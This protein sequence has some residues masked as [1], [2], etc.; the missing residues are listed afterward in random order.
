VDDRRPLAVD[1]LR[2][3]SDRRAVDRTQRLVA[4]ADP[5]GGIVEV[6]EDGHRHA[7][8]LWGSRSRRDDDAVRVQVANP[9]HVDG[10]V[11]TDEHLVGRLADVLDEVVREGVVVVDD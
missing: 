9:R 11:P 10:V 2:G 4:E 5:E 1:H 8:L 6:G 3:V 7:R